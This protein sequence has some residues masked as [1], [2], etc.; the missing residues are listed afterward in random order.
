MYIIHEY[1]I[2]ILKCIVLKQKYYF[3][4]RSMNLFLISKKLNLSSIL[5][6]LINF[7]LY[8]ENFVNGSIATLYQFE[9]IISHVLTSYYD[10]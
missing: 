2:Y 4:F 6:C 10:S 7:N 3:T 5:I 8:M 9:R 1:T